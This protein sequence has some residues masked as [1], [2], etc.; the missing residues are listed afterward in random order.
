MKPGQSIVKLS[1]CFKKVGLECTWAHPIITIYISP[2]ENES[3]NGRIKKNK[4]LPK[5]VKTPSESIN[6][7][8]RGAENSSF[9][10]KFSKFYNGVC[11][12]PY[13]ALPKF[14]A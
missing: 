5:N 8:K 4:K 13:P 6:G 2:Y 10:Q 7:L 3:Q 11:F 1:K 12:R 14:T 9:S